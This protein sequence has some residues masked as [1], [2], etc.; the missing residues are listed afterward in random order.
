MPQGMGPGQ[1][2]LEHGVPGTKGTIPDVLTPQ[3]RLLYLLERI[4]SGP[5]SQLRSLYDPGVTL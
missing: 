1:H 2:N 5:M 3:D 4:R